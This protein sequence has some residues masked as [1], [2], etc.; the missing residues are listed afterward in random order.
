MKMATVVE[1]GYHGGRFKSAAARRG[2]MRLP[3]CSVRRGT[4]L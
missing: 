4:G 3:L 1:G 2:G